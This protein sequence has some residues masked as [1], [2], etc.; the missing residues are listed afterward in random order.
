MNVA[1][2]LGSWW[3]ARERSQSDPIP[4]VKRAQDS[5]IDRGRVLNSAELARRCDLAKSTVHTLA[6]DPKPGHR[7]TR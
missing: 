2:L 5:A 4:G 7:L 6:N 1:T 3:P